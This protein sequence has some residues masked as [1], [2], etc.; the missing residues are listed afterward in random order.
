MNSIILLLTLTVAY[1]LATPTNYGSSKSSTTS[2]AAPAVTILKQIN[3]LNEDGSYTFGYEASDGSFRFEN[4][5]ANGYLTGRYGYVDSYGKTQETEYVAG[6]LSGQSVGFQARGTSISQDGRKALPFP[7]IQTAPKSVEQK[8][9]DYQYTSVDDDEDGFPDSAPVNGGNVRV[10]SLA[11]DAYNSGTTVVRVAD[12]SYAVSNVRVSTPTKTTYE[13][14]AGDIRLVSPSKSSYGPVVGVVEK[15]RKIE[16]NYGKIADA[17]VSYVPA[18][19]RVTNA[20]E[21]DTSFIKPNAKPITTNIQQLS[22]QVSIIRSPT[23]SYGNSAV[24]STGKLDEFLKSLE[25]N[26][27]NVGNSYNTNQ[28]SGA[29]TSNQGQFQQDFQIQQDVQPIQGDSISVD[30]IGFS[31]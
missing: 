8:A 14:T 13:P 15:N 26:T 6:K 21:A 20:A 16:D 25:T 3:Q 22:G 27:K 29:I 11:K 10:V 30:S 31:V 5:D 19:V 12:Q 28:S 7:F 1:S 17:R 23:T 9:L 18:V 2:Y 24:K 4:M